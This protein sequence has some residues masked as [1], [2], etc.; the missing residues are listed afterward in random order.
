[1]MGA[2]GAS[3]DPVYVDDV[4]ST[5]LYEANGSS[6]PR[7]ITNG[8][9]LAGE[10]GLVWTKGRNISDRHALVDNERGIRYHL[11][12]D[13]QNLARD[14]NWFNSFNSDGYTFSTNDTELNYS[15]KDYVSWTFRKAPGFFDVV[16][17]TGTGSV[18]TVAHSLGSVPGMILIKCTTNDS[19]WSVYHRS[20]GATKNM[21]LNNTSAADTQA[22]PFNDTEPTSTHF[23]VN[24]DGDVNGSGKGYVAYVFAHNDASFGTGGDESIITCGTYTG[25]NGTQD[26]GVGFEPQFVLIKNTNGTSNWTMLDVTR[27]AANNDTNQAFLYSNAPDV[28]TY[29]YRAYATHT[30][31]GFKTES[32]S[33]INSSSN[34]YIYMAIRR[35]NKP[36]ETGT[37]VFHAYYGTP[38]SGSFIT[39][40]FPFDLQIA[41]EASANGNNWFFTRQLGINTWKTTSQYT[42][43][44]ISNA[45]DAKAASSNTKSVYTT[46]YGIASAWA[47]N[48]MIFYTFKRAPGFFDVVNYFG[49]NS[50]RTILH[51]LGAVPELMIVKDTSRAEEWM[52]YHAASGANKWLKLNSN[53]SQSNDSGGDMWGGTT[54]TSSV[55]SLGNSS[56]TNHNGSIIIAYLFATLPGISK[57]GSY[58]G[59]GNAINVDCGF[60]NGARFVLIKRTDV[61]G[62]W[63][64]MDSV[65]GI[66]SGNDKHFAL[67]TNTAEGTSSD[68][69]NPLNTGFTV[70]ASAPN[71]INQSGGTYI[72]LAIA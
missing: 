55:F 41:K 14:R 40:G 71:D 31:F 18:R 9:D 58:S 61:G 65:R 36:P 62:D 63:D 7:T 21:H 72:F 32:S 11:A 39:N 8:I 12:S 69:I 27:G 1:M 26:I 13:E 38:S 56:N 59:T 17:Y 42:R 53:D 68:F 34:T 33:E 30:G 37:D 6:S 66:T 64:V 45:T 44:L 5:F 22:G 67:N 10:G 25:N 15:D 19:D 28:E 4:F 47:N 48:L 50:P 3:G 16:T 35:P 60:T 29:P 52:V 24:Y 46:K 2:A 70:S 57:V 43:Q 54:P 51:N 49:N 23:T 20:M